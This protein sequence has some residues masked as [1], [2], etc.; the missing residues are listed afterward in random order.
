[1]EPNHAVATMEDPRTVVANIEQKAMRLSAL[2]R[3]IDN[4]PVDLD[5]AVRDQLT[6]VLNML[7]CRIA[8]TQTLMT[9]PRTRE[10]S[11]TAV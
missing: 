8:A 5:Q 11:G 4:H 7:G 9:G 10:G 6:E 3:E 1:M 2:L